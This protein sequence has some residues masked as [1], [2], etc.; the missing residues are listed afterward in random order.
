MFIS[1]KKRF[2]TRNQ[3]RCKIQ[4][5]LN[6][7]QPR[8]CYHNE[9]LLQRG[10]FLLQNK[11]R[12]S[13]SKT[14][15]KTLCRHHHEHLTREMDKYS[16][17]RITKIIFDSLK[18]PEIEEVLDDPIFFFRQNDALLAFVRK[19]VRKLEARYL[20]KKFGVKLRRVAT[21][22]SQDTRRGFVLSPESTLR[23]LN[24]VR[25]A[26]KEVRCPA[27]YWAKKG[28]YLIFLRL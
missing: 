16:L 8:Y 20:R 22:A 13:K 6:K 17:S 15:F 26:P 14:E 10:N 11:L 19:R 4:S 2:K 25:A 21:E 27:Y 5:L 1:S 3:I 12:K 23:K 9:Y 18:F 28:F 7:H 24:K